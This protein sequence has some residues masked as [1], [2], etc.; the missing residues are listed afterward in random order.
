MPSRRPSI[1]RSLWVL[2]NEAMLLPKIQRPKERISARADASHAKWL[3][4]PM[5]SAWLQI[6]RTRLPKNAPS[7][8]AQTERH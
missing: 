4:Y 5:R 6:N 2:R 8:S 7:T 1:R 3:W